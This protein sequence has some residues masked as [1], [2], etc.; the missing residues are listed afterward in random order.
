MIKN[1]LIDLF[2]K[3]KQQYTIYLFI[4]ISLLSFGNSHSYAEENRA[5]NFSTINL[6]NGLSQLSVLD[7]C[8]DAKGYIWFA[9]RNGLNK[10]DGATFTVYKHSN[11]D[12][13]S[14]TDNHITKLL[15]DDIH[16]GLWIGTNN[17]LN[18]LNQ[19]TNLITNYQ[20]A[21]YPSLPSNSILSLCLDKSGNLW[22]GTR[23]GLCR[24]MPESNTFKTI[25]FDGQLERESITSLYMD[26]EE[27]LYIG[28]HN[29]GL[30]ICDKNLNILQKLN[31]ESTPSLSDNAI[32]CIFEDSHQQIW[33][34]TD[35]KGLNKWN[36][37]Q[38]T[39]STF[40]EHNSGL[41]DNYIRC[42]QE[43]NQ[44]LIIGTF[45]GLSVLDLTDDAITK[46]NTFEANRN[47]LSHFSVR[48]LCVDRAGTLWVGTY[49]GGVN[50]YNPLNNRFVFY[51]PLGN[52][53]QKLYNIFGPM[54]Y[55][56]NSLWIATEGGGLLQF[57]PVTKEYANYL[58]EERP[59]GMHN[60]NIIKSLM[61]EGENI[62]CGTN[63]GGLY[64]FHI[65][66]KRFSLIHQFNEKNLGIYTIYRDA[67]GDI[68]L[69]TTSR[70]GLVRITK[71]KKVTRKF[72]VG[73]KEEAISFSS[74]RAFLPLRENVYLIGTRSFGLYEYD[75]EKRTLIQYST[76]EKEPSRKLENNYITSILRKK[77][78]EIWVGTFGAGIYQY[79]EGKGIIRHIGTEE[80]LTNE[81]VYTLV[82]YNQNIWASIDNGIAEINTKTGQVYA[83][84]CFA[85][86]ETLEFTPQGG[87]C[88]PNGEVYFSGSN[89][90]LSFTPRSLIKNNMMPPVVLTQLTVN[91]KVI[92]PGDKSR[93]LEANPDDAATVTLAY[94]Q[95]NFSIAYCALNYILH[96]QNQYAYKLIGHDE[97]W[98]YV[99]T[100]KEAFYTNIAP[101]KYTFHVIA[102]NND[103]VWN[104]QGKTL[105]IVIL[106]PWWKTTWAYIIYAL[107]FI[108]ITYTIGYYMYSKHKLELNLRMRQMEKQRMEEFH[109]TKI[110]LFT[111]F[112]HEL[113]TPLTL[114]ISPIDELV[115]QAEVPLF[116]KTKL[117]LVLKN[118]RRLLLLVNQL[119]DLQKNQSGSL[120]LRLTHS[121]LN[122][123][124]LEIYYTFKQ[125]AESKQITFQYE[126][127]EG[128]I[129]AYFD[130]S[131]LEKAVF[132]L[133]S[134]AFKFTSPGETISLRLTAIPDNEI[135]QREFGKI[136]SADPTFAIRTDSD[137]Y[138]IIQVADTGKGIPEAARTHIFDPFYQVSTPQAA[139]DNVNGTGIGLS[140]TQSIVHLHHGAISVDSNQPKGSIFTI[141]LPNNEQAQPVE[142]SVKNNLSEDEREEQAVVGQVLESEEE[143]PF[144]E[145]KTILLVEDNE[146]IRSYV[147]EHL[148][149][150]YRVLEADN[151][152]EAFNIVLK[153][154]PDLVVT[155]IM[156]PGVDGLELCSMIKN[157][158][159]TGHI[160]V[161]LLTARTMVMHVK[162]GF[163]SG[164]DD[165][166]VKP[167]NV[168]VLLVRIYNLLVQREKLKSMYGKNFSLQSMGI[169][170][171]SADDKFMQ[172]LFE[173]IQNHLAS[174]DLKVDMIC[175]EMGFSRSNFYRK[176]K[177]VTDLSLNDL[178]RHKRLEVAA[179]LLKEADM[180]VTEVSIATGFSTLAYF[181]KC[182]KSDYGVSPTEYIK[183]QPEEREENEEE[184]T[185]PSRE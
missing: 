165:Y 86:L 80:G 156:M 37:T 47:N 16:G 60:K 182:F 170:A 81:E 74:I 180:N 103:G 117:D 22:I 93:L 159:Q 108:G 50:Y 62:W 51:H 11:Q 120:T 123:F 48:S 132:N 121:D 69:G 129:P 36:P 72:P 91:N 115:R 173:I 25:A 116:I 82:E 183:G 124:L 97:D 110:R 130:Q 20:I 43:Q 171:S 114:I 119:M 52:S 73:E 178:I 67:K 70:Q 147:K 131:L 118:A 100:R 112:S 105:E 30:L 122:A 106:S 161:I 5:F 133:L 33:I 49:S 144:L 1:N 28:T 41:T 172:K 71:D 13:N 42:I 64:C 125:I 40:L 90:F 56:A 167:F 78:G 136:L 85:G 39:I 184:T 18:Y 34:G 177:A 153:E 66:T 154:F 57:N 10:Y 31:K 113:R 32:S 19:K 149:R 101:G 3:R 160:P 8:Q 44:R 63:N 179:Q 87:I 152:A 111:N 150:H 143:L 14:L 145:G 26:K 109:Q 53:E 7:I 98:N 155:D 89:G 17:G 95:N 169:E 104:S 107:L 24:W 46:Y 55:S 38:Q 58:L 137:N 23:L 181:T 151:G 134:N 164:A 138:F 21:D 88:L 162:E 2:T 157:D 99:G 76:E 61:M 158:L 185:A 168:D 12:A 6:N 35:M 135:L 126:A 59:V 102:S 4:F 15:P 142:E 127:P 9:T 175:D 92:Q 146:D 176:L 54:V 83:Y 148:E 65:P 79:Q 29:K 77:N 128:E 163:L 174:P 27:R 141:V 45:D 140:L 166:V 139:N 84:D 75:V 94:N 68:W 96:E